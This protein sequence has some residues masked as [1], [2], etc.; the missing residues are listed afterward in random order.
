MKNKKK[1]IRPNGAAAITAMAIRRNQLI[2]D[3]FVLF[4][5]HQ[6]PKRCNDLH[7]PTIMT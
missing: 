3:V 4:P 5:F 6:I 1:M 2:D 7:D